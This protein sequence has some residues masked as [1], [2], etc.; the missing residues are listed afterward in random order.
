M[1]QATEE[2]TKDLYDGLAREIL[3]DVSRE[4][5]TLSRSFGV[6]NI[7]SMDWGTG[8]RDADRAGQGPDQLR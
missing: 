1:L 6:Q 7:E 4:I 2:V 5:T 3:S 8:G